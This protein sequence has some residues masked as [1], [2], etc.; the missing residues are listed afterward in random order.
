MPELRNAVFKATSPLRRLTAA[1]RSPADFVIGGAQKSGTTYLADLL[2]AQPG[3]YLPP[4]KEIH[5][6]NVHWDRGV[7]WYSSH[8]Q[9]RSSSARQIDA[10]PSYMIH[11]AVPERIRTVNSDAKVIF[12]LR[13]PVARAYSH[14]QHN[15]RAGLEKLDFPAAL[16]AEEVRIA[17]DLEAMA[18]NP[19]EIGI[20][21][22]LYSYRSRGT[23][24]LYLERFAQEFPSENIL[25]LDS[26]RVF[27]HH[28]A[29]I[30]LLEDFVGR[31]IALDPGK[32][33]STNTGTYA[34]VAGETDAASVELREF[35]DPW[36]SRL[37]EL[38]GR[39]FSWM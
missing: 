21:F 24:A 18:G 6:Y 27:R 15:L 30:G 37:V 1:Q 22:A 9:L 39:T 20:S 4:I 33:L 36:D 29:E 31:R 23:Y 12:I 32:R 8:F 19:E 38:T 17:A 26:E 2:D 7:G 25:V 3:F 13:D 14:F 34:R 28:P 16:A 11:P 5:F 10:S 35:F